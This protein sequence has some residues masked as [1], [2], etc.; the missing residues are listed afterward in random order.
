MSSSVKKPKWIGIFSAISFLALLFSFGALV[1]F[2]VGLYLV[3][4]VV[5]IMCAFAQLAG[6]H[7]GS[8]F[9]WWIEKLQFGTH[10]ILIG[11]FLIFGTILLGVSLKGRLEI[12][13]K[14]YGG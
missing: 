4:G 13:W 12:N 8:I 9:D 2:R 10:M 1:D 5:S 14:D 6:P 7:Y 3:G 11:V